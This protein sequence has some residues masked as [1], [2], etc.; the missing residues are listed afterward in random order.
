MY[1]INRVHND[2][3]AQNYQQMIVFTHEFHIFLS[4]VFTKH[5]VI[6]M[7]AFLIIKYIITKLI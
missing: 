4:L 2:E 7:S 5:F 6:L 3:E 1:M